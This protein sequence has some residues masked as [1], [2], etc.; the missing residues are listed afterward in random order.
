MSGWFQY[1]M[2]EFIEEKKSVCHVPK[3]YTNCITESSE[4]LYEVSCYYLY[5]TDKETEAQ[6][7]YKLAQGHMARK[8]HKQSIRWRTVGDI[9]DVYLEK[10]NTGI[11]FQD[12]SLATITLKITGSFQIWNSKINPLCCVHDS[13]PSL[14][15]HICIH[16]TND[17]STNACW[18]LC[19][20]LGM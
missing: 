8:W 1:T 18:Q 2:L 9:M 4:Q 3:L 14:C 5:S 20:A 15:M 10:A 13:F 7:R 11:A 17:V 6:S 19:S 12:G 16:L